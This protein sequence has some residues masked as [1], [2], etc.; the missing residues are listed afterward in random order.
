MGKKS[1]NNN[2]NNRKMS[3]SIASTSPCTKPCSG[4]TSCESN[5]EATQSSTAAA[6]V[7]T[8]KSGTPG[9]TCE[10]CHKTATLTCSRC[11]K[12]GGGVWYC[13]RECQKQNWKAHKARC[14]E[15]YQVGQWELHKKAFDRIIEKYKLN[16]EQKSTEISEL[17]SGGADSVT[18]AHFASKFGMD[19]QE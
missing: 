8:K 1:N 19:V 13:S 17:L 16:T 14:T 5:N 4:T 9:K 7:G 2:N 11:K 15:D 10:V 6:E 18:S 3:S 12:V